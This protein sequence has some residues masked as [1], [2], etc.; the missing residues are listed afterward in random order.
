VE[1][2]FGFGHSHWHPFVATLLQQEKSGNLNYKDL[3]LKQYFEEWNPKNAGQAIAGFDHTPKSFT[4][5]LPYNVVLA[6]W[7]SWSPQ[8]FYQIIAQWNKKDYIEHSRPDF[9]LM[10]DGSNRF[11]PVSSDFGKFEFDRLLKIYY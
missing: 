3:L 1:S 5:L 9:D 7:T 8:N 10:I 6:P 4:H 11:G 2:G